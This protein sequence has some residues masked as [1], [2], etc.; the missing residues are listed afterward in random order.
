MQSDIIIEIINI[1]K[2]IRSLRRDSFLFGIEE[3]GY[4]AAQKDSVAVYTGSAIRELAP[5]KTGFIIF[6]P[7]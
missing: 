6:N 1:N 2:E 4:I 5:Y 7:H 3:S